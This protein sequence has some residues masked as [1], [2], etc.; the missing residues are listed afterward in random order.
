VGSTLSET[1]ARV[2]DV[3]NSWRLDQEMGKYLECK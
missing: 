2:D 1:K 3:K